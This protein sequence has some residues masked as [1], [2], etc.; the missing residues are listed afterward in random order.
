MLSEHDCK[1]IL[2]KNGRKY[3]DS[4]IKLLKEKLYQLAEIDYQLFKN[5]NNLKN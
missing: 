2:N 1:M 4:D 5:N 3:S